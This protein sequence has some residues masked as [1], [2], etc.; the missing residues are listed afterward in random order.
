M[1]NEVDERAEGPELFHSFGVV[2]T[3]WGLVPIFD[4]MSKVY[5]IYN[6]PPP[7]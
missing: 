4:R 6:D 1:N 5:L 3:Q 2:S 7:S